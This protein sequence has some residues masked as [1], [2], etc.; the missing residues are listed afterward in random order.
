MS[1]LVSYTTHSIKELYETG[2][3]AIVNKTN[4]KFYIGSASRIGI[5]PSDSGFY[6]RWYSHIAS[7]NSNSSQC[8]YLQNA[9][10]KYG[11]ENFEFKIIHK[12]PPEECIQYEQLYLNFLCPHYNILITANSPKGIKRSSE[13][14]NQMAVSCG[15]KEVVLISPFWEEFTCVSCRDFAKRHNLHQSHLSEVVKGKIESHK[16]WF[17]KGN[18]NIPQWRFKNR[19]TGEIVKTSH[20]ATFSKAYSLDQSSVSKLIN[21]KRKS[22]K[23]WVL[24]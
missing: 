6:T 1:R 18:P 20:K 4:D 8:T 21:K 13:Y 24:L 7:L 3:Y 11:E 5:S 14:K 22:C 2:V 16:G 12:C 23:N 10:N 9:W 19:K 17:K 15:S